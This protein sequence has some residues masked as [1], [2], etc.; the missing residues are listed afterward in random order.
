[1]SLCSFPP[2]SH[3]HNSFQLKSYE[4]VFHGISCLRLYLSL[5]FPS[6]QLCRLHL[7]VDGACK[8]APPQATPFLLPCQFKLYILF[9][10]K[11]KFIFHQ[12][13]PVSTTYFIN[14]CLNNCQFEFYIQS[15]VTSVVQLKKKHASELVTCLKSFCHLFSYSTS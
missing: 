6:L 3:N 12:W 8:L 2:Y 4:Y 13:L 10:A 9:V 15:I 1:M 7:T 14:C 5:N 11:L